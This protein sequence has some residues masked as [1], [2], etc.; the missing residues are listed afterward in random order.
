MPIADGN[1]VLQY[2]YRKEFS[3]SKGMQEKKEEETQS[4]YCS[5]E[6]CMFC[7]MSPVSHFNSTHQKIRL[8]KC[9][10]LLVCVYITWLRTTVRR[11]KV[12]TLKARRVKAPPFIIFLSLSP[13]VGILVIFIFFAL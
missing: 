1:R 13:T 8:T 7:C 5:S 12:A 2:K 4:Y 3:K 11:R 6:Q 9:N 10:K